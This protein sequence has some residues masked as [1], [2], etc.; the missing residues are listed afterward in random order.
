MGIFNLTLL[1][2]VLIVSLYLI[3]PILF[4]KRSNK[5]TLLSM[6]LLWIYSALIPTI[7]LLIVRFGYNHFLFNCMSIVYMIVIISPF[8]VQ[9]LSIY[10]FFT[11]SKYEQVSTHRVI[12]VNSEG[13]HSAK[14]MEYFV[15]LILPFI[16][17][18]NSMPDK[19]TIL[20]VITILVFL[21]FR[22]EIYYLNLPLLMFLYIHEVTLS[23][24]SKYFLISKKKE[25]KENLEYKIIRFPEGLK[26][27]ILFSEV[28][29]EKDIAK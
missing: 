28:I 22:L 3:S 5:V 15:I 27:A 18:S 20:Y 17:I 13:F 6:K 1:I 11:A 2:P 14:T 7:I 19:L 29:A 26:V 10:K 8:I 25:V 23:D 4:S 16:T 12:N 21:F 24:G 9:L